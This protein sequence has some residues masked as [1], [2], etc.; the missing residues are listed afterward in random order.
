[1]RGIP[2]YDLE[3]WP[4]YLSAARLLADGIFLNI[5]TCTKFINK[6]TVL[7]QIYQKLD[8][9]YTKDQIAKIYDS[10][11]LDIPRKTVITSYNTKSYQVDGLDFSK[12]PETYSFK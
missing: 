3:M 4:G 8:R 9:S 7:E 11:N 10:S 2:E 5:D 1:M 6:T 12:N